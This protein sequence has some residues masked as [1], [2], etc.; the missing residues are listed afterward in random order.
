MHPDSEAGDD[1]VGV[2]LPDGGE[3]IL[4]PVPE[5]KVAKHRVHLCLRPRGSSRD[6]E[7]QRLLAAGATWV[8]GH[9]HPDGTGWAVLADPEDNEF[10]VLRSE[11]SEPV[12]GST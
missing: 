1:E 7:V 12:P 3:L 5:P 9:R 2:P 6:D 10:F 11:S 4:Q 8:A